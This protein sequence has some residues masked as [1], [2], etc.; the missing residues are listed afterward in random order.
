LC[1]REWSNLTPRTRPSTPIPNERV[2]VSL[3]NMNA[4]RKSRALISL[5]SIAVAYTAAPGLAQTPDNTPMITIE[6]PQFNAVLPQGGVTATVRLRWNLDK[7]SSGAGLNGTE[8]HE[9]F[10]RKAAVEET[11]PAN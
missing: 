7:N 3:S 6:A 4:S 1:F 5:L 9:P 2:I 10:H 8:T 11:N